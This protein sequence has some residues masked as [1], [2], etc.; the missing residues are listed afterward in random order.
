MIESSW[1]NRNTGRLYAHHPLR[2]YLTDTAGNEKFSAA[3]RAFTPVDWVAGKEY[4]VTT[5]IRVS[6]KLQPGTYEVRIA[7]TDPESGK[8]SVR[9][10]VEGEDTRMRSRLG[11]I[12][13]LPARAGR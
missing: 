11:T 13:I 7:I 12:R 6:E 9:L 5:L 1:V 3:D 2:I 4:P 10:A 8:P